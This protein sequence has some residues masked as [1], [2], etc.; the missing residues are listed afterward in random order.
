MDP[1]AQDLFV[2]GS[3]GTGREVLDVALALGLPVRGFLDERT[4][5]TTVR[6]LPVTLPSEAVAGS[7]VI[8]IADPQVRS[9]LVLELLRL[10]PTTLVHPVAVVGPDTV[11]GAGCVVMAL[12]HV[13]SSVRLG[14]HVQ[15]QYGATI[16]H[17]CV[18]EDYV[19]VLPGARVSG[20]VHLAAGSTVG[21][22]AVVLQGRA[23]GS[24]AFVGAGA[25][26]TRDVG[27]GVIVVGS[28]A[29]P[30]HQSRCTS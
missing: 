26:V 22:G 27:P 5:G 13:S 18:L 30:L 29:R 11:L 20:S 16:G 8:G 10:A 28:P 15:V 4:A 23:V 3:G 6:G 17:D 14:D 1:A 12:A 9:R 21:S 19:T 25:V 2:V 7:V 24:G